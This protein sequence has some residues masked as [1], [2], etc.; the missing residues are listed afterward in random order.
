MIDIHS[1]ILPGVD[2]GARSFDESVEI[3]RMLSSCGVTDIVATPHFIRETNF[4]SPVANNRKIVEELKN[5]LKAEAIDVNIY[6]GNEIYIDEDIVGLLRSGQISH[7]ADS[8]YL[9]IELPLNDEF[10]NYEGYLCDLMQDGYKVILA[11]PERYAIAQEDYGILEDLYELGVLFQ[12]NIGSVYGKY[13]KSAQKLLKKLAKDKKIFTFGSDAHHP[14]S[15]QS[16]DLAYKKLLKYYNE[17]ELR[18][19]LI[20]NPQKI[21]N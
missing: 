8:E 17:R 1:H 16:F 11:H 10:S 15:S 9:L 6:L 21:I 5:R 19:L 20:K 14:G 3:A 12:C 7:L 2:D 13:G 4:V 18:E